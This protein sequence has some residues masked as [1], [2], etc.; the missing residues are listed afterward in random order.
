MKIG[1]REF[2]TLQGSG[3]I[4]TARTIMKTLT[5][6]LE[7]LLKKE[8]FSSFLVRILYDVESIVD[9]D[10]YESEILNVT[11]N[12]FPVVFVRISYLLNS[13]YLSE[14][15]NLEKEFD[16]KMLRAFSTG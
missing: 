7:Q 16:L 15:L 2:I 5:N 9:E 10:L 6:R 4:E 1:G 14:V 12:T 11:K 3:D 13:N 8:V